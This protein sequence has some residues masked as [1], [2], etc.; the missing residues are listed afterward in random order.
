MTKEAEINSRHIEFLTVALHFNAIVEKCGSVEAITFISDLSKILPY[1]YLK[2][3]LVQT[4]EGD[5]EEI[6][7]VVTHE[8][9]NTIHNS[10]KQCLRK[11]YVP[12]FI[13]EGNDDE[14]HYVLISELISD[15]YQDTKSFS[16]N[17][18]MS[19]ED[20][21]EQ[22]ADWLK[23]TFLEYWGKKVL[24][25][26]LGLHRIISEEE[27]SDVYNSSESTDQEDPIFSKRQKDWG[28][29]DDL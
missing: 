8:E 25:V 22:V 5:L 6:P 29:R 14:G 26:Q 28:Y 15:I 11:L 24:N 4:S 13:P 20:E 1:L 27:D 7:G 9:Y 12:V 16:V 3:L 10:V 2:A 18:R 19:S 23:Q 21:R 17:Y